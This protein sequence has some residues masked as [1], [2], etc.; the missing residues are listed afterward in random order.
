MREILD[1]VMPAAGASSR[2][3]AWKPLLP[4][5]RATLVEAAVGG[6]LAAGLRVLL[7]VGHRGREIS[8]LFAGRE[9]V[10]IVENPDWERGMLGSIQ[11]ALPLVESE[12]FF[13]A[14]A[15]MPGIAAGDYLA[16]AA[17]W[18][19][20]GRAAPSRDDPA[21]DRGGI[22]LFAS[23]QGTAGHPVLL[24]RA[25]SADILTLGPGE[26][27][28]PFLFSRTHRLI[29]RG[30]GALMDLDTPEDYERCRGAA[31]ERIPD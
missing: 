25:W 15:D 3:G 5:G 21:R 1:C 26:R 30:P 14:N 10:V 13:C 24:P 27:L 23:H 31:G 11:K 29:E 6:A 2:M 4:W 18:E 20:S 19:A 12:A 28:R 17:T 22:A 7:V 16:L 9:G 8:G